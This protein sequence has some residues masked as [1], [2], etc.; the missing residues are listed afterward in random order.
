MSTEASAPV[1]KAPRLRPLIIAIVVG[2]GVAVAAGLSIRASEYHQL[3]TWSHEQEIPTVALM[4]P[5]AAGTAQPM[6]LPGHI[7]AWTSAPLHAQVSGYLKSWTHDIGSK[8]AAGDVL[9]VI[10]TPALDQQYAMA[11]ATLVKAAA[12]QKLAQATSQRWQD[13]LD[14]HSVSKQEADEKQSDAEVAKANV[15][16]AQ[17]DVDRLAALEAFKSVVAPFAGTITSR[18]TDVGD[19]VSS[20]NAA[21]PALFT[22][23]DTSRMRLY[24]SIPQAYADAVKPGMTVTLSVLEHPGTQLTATLIGSS[25]A[26]NPLSGSI[27]A[28]FE[29]PNQNGQLLPG[30]YAD[31]QLPVTQEVN[32]HTVAASALLF[33]AQGPQLAVLGSGDTVALRDIHISADYGETLVVDR[34]L[35]P[36]DRVIDHPPD[37]LMQ[38]QK[39]HVATEENGHGPVAKA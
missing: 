8:V 20:T 38:G 28:Q 17:A 6:T 22:V 16:A 13:L 9:G 27:L 26:V 37:S 31:V 29:V 7:D 35:K 25:G 4:A 24:V 12:S 2:A 33:R 1:P 11:K 15:T 10:N 5:I 18:Q 30:D 36:G 21:A 32:A 19:L 34:G 39:V 3:A 14:D 23:S